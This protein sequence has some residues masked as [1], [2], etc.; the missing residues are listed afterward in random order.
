MTANFGQAALYGMSLNEI[1]LPELLAEVGYSTMALGK[2]HL[3]HHVEY[4]PQHRGFE[5]WVGIPYSWDM[6]CGDGEN[7]VDW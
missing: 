6:G 4:L 2:W 3:G 5:H 7:G 1:L